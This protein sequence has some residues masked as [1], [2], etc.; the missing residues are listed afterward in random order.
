[1]TTNRKLTIAII[2]LLVINLI[3]VSFLIKDHKNGDESKSTKRQEPAEIIINKLDF[4]ESQVTALYELKEKHIKNV[5]AKDAEIREIKKTIF[6]S[7]GYDEGVNIDSLSTVIGGIQKDIEVSHYQH[8]LRIKALCRDD[9]KE[10]FTAL[11]KEL[12]EIF[13]R[14]RNR[15]S[16]KDKKTKE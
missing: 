10:K 7:L 11:S 6:N 2:A 12:S 13:N 1:M 5:R 14:K 9:Q 3:V 4:D 8:F 16:S 15:R